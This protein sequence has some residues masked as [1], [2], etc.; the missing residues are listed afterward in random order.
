MMHFIEMNEPQLAPRVCY[1][2]KSNRTRSVSAADVRSSRLSSLQAIVPL[3]V[4][5]FEI[6]IISHS[7]RNEEPNIPYLVPK[8]QNTEE[9][10]SESLL[11]ATLHI[12]GGTGR[13]AVVRVYG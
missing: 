2:L 7:S 10:C 6:F 3:N 13:S 5:N 1:M 11:P 4:E 12:L 8:L 9:L